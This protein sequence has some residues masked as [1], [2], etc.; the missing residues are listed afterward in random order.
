MSEKRGVSLLT[1]IARHPVG[2]TNE[3]ATGSNQCIAPVVH[4]EQSLRGS[5]SWSIIVASMQLVRPEGRP[6]H[7]DQS[8]R[9]YLCSLHRDQ[10]LSGRTFACCSTEQERC[11]TWDFLLATRHHHI[12]AK[13]SFYDCTCV[14]CCMRNGFVSTHSLGVME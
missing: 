10:K 4:T 7:P 13:A 9:R 2:A 14:G 6:Y 11:I 12:A 1:L 5:R 8:S 3:S